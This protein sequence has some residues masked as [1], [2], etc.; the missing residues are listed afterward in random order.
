MQI[1]RFLRRTTRAFRSSL[2]R[3]FSL[4]EL[5]V[6]IAILAVITGLAIPSLRDFLVS[7]EM[8]NMANEFANDM[9][10]ARQQA[11]NRNRC[12]TM[13]VASD[14]FSDTPACTNAPPNNWTR[15]WIVVTN[16][17]CNAT[18]GVL[19]PA[20]RETIIYTNATSDAAYTIGAG[21][22]GGFRRRITFD[23]QGRP[24]A[25]RTSFSLAPV[26]LDSV[27]SKY[28]RDICLSQAGRVRVIKSGDPC[29]D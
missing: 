13:C 20:R 12:V 2:Q 6:T 8:S 28:I 29:N 24:T 10:N 9:Q 15:G 17:T 14:V 21:G 16:P 1:S 22:G 19:D 27:N 23:Q 5:M 4:A 11:I 26:N 18:I 7:V 3:G 25:G